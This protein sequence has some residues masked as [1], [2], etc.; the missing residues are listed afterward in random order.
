[1]EKLV[2]MINTPPI[3]VVCGTVLAV[4]NMFTSGMILTSLGILGSILN[5]GLDQ[6]KENQ[7]REERKELYD[8]VAKNIGTAIPLWTADKSGQVH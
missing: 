5:F 2:K 1:M 8:N 3:L 4:N 6:H 7:D